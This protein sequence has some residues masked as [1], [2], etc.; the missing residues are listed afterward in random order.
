MLNE[1]I[2]RL[3]IEMLDFNADILVNGIP[4]GH[5]ENT[6]CAFLQISNAFCMSVPTRS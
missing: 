5:Q 4:A 3:N 6:F 2:V 1:D